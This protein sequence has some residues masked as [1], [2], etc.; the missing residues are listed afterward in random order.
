MS[1]PTI[2]PSEARRLID[3]GALLIDIREADEHARENIPGA[4]HL[5]L[6]KLDEADLAVHQGKPEA[7]HRARI[8][9]S[10]RVA[11]LAHWTAVIKAAGVTL[12]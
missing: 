9:R 6:S 3:S 8:V 2:A 4:R 7:R 5:P 12:D 1:L 11:V 10:S